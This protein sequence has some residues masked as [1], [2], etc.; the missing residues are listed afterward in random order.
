VTLI[1]NGRLASRP[2]GLLGVGPL[3]DDH[4]QKSHVRGVER[5]AG[6]AQAGQGSCA[7]EIAS[8][9]AEFTFLNDGAVQDS[10]GEFVLTASDYSF[11][12]L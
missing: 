12:V 2:R 4:G 11:S 1:E 9:P 3:A 6:A 8:R 10:S 7:G 5:E